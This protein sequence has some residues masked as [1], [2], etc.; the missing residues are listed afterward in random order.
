V[1]ALSTGIGRLRIQFTRVVLASASFTLNEPVGQLS[2]INAN[3]EF[4]LIM[5]ATRNGRINSITFQCD[6]AASG[7]VNEAT[8]WI[9]LT[10][11]RGILRSVPSSK[12][13]M[14]AESAVPASPRFLR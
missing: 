12:K 13:L 8:L 14:C 4:G 7:G 11:F 9:A 5:I 10:T 2:P 6:R 3:N 1:G